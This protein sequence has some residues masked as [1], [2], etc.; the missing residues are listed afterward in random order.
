MKRATPRNEVTE[1]VE[2]TSSNSAGEEAQGVSGGTGVPDRGS[3]ANDHGSVGATSDL[4][5]FFAVDVNVKPLLEWPIVDRFGVIDP[6]PAAQR[7]N[8]FLND[9][10]TNLLR[11]FQPPAGA[12][13]SVQLGERSHPR[14]TGIEHLLPGKTLN[15]VQTDPQGAEAP[16][17]DIEHS[18]RHAFRQLCLRLLLVFVSA[19]ITSSNHQVIKM[20]WGAVNIILSV[21]FGFSK[22]HIWLVFLIPK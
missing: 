10:R 13:Q 12:N 3:I 4:G 14:N 5:Q 7:V 21:S 16:N 20:F 9:I 8:R 11:G 19:P 6:Q 15:E 18:L 2:D 17:T 22:V 1:P